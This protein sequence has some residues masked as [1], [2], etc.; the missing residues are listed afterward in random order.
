MSVVLVFCL[1]PLRVISVLPWRKY[2][3]SRW[4]E[5]GLFLPGSR[6]GRAVKLGRTTGKSKYWVG[7]MRDG[8]L[9]A[10]TPNTGWNNDI[11]NTT[12]ERFHPKQKES[13]IPSALEVFQPAGTASL[14][15]CN[16]YRRPESMSHFDTHEAVPLFSMRG[17][18]GK[19]CFSCLFLQCDRALSRRG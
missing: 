9:C 3:N 12:L 18:N 11:L 2:E 17:W 1:F 19:P 5:G 4:F 7:H 13:M 10:S 16:A 6:W 15:R 8:M 14:R